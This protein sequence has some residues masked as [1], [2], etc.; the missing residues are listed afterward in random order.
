MRFISDQPEWPSPPA[1][2][3]D[4]AK[5]E[6]T[7][8]AK[9]EY[10]PEHYQSACTGKFHCVP[11]LQALTSARTCQSRSRRLH[12][13]PMRPTM[14]WQHAH[15]LAVCEAAFD[16]RYGTSRSSGTTC[17]RSDDTWRPRRCEITHICDLSAFDPVTSQTFHPLNE[18]WPDNARGALLA[19]ETFVVRLREAVLPC[20]I[21]KLPKFQLEM[22]MTGIS[23]P[24]LSWPATES[25]G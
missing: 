4:A 25:P 7:K 5:W 6:G 15:L 22:S 2:V 9:S 11:F 21:P 1:L 23:K 3:N 10:C 24:T 16:S 18:T 19:C 17:P 12:V 13:L 20:P 8:C 14:S